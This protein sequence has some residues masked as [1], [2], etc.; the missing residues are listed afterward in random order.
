M[1]LGSMIHAVS[2]QE[3]FQEKSQLEHLLNNVDQPGTWSQTPVS[4]VKTGTMGNTSDQTNTSPNQPQYFNQQ[5]GSLFTRQ[6]ILRIMLGGTSGGTPFSDGKS[7]Q[8]VSSAASDCQEAENQASRAYNAEQRARY[9]RNKGLRADDASEADYAASASRAA[10]DR[11]Y[12]ASE[13]GDPVAKKYAAKAR[14]AADRARANAD[15]ARYYAD[16]SY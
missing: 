15:Q 1:C 3:T 13:N 2:A 16:S 6:Q 10:S 5:P 11:V 9:E 4:G 7:R 14:A 8:G 12:Y